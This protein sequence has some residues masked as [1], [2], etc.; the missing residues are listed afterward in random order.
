MRSD[1]SFSNVLK[2]LPIKVDDRFWKP[3]NAV[4]RMKIIEPQQSKLMK[5][6]KIEPQRSKLRKR[7]RYGSSYLFKK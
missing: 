4:L 3:F 5:A 1:K 6:I 7:K 2:H